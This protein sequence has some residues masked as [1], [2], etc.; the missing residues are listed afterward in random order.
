MLTHCWQRRH[1]GGVKTEP[2]LLAATEE[3]KDGFEKC[4]HFTLSLVHIQEVLFIA[5]RRDWGFC[6]WPAFKIIELHSYL[7]M[8]LVVLINKWRRLHFNKDTVIISTQSWK[9]EINKINLR[10]S[11]CWILWSVHYLLLFVW[12]CN[13]V[14][15]CGRSQLFV[16]L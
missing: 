9:C 1:E 3:K 4:N 13:S 5:L 8:Y 16:S 2:I 11:S 6:Q 14:R 7:W 12:H 15:S 10:P